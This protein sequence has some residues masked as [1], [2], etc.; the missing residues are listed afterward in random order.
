MNVFD[1]RLTPLLN[2]A[3]GSFAGFAQVTNVNTTQTQLLSVM[4]DTV[5]PQRTLDGVNEAWLASS[6]GFKFT[7]DGQEADQAAAMWVGPNE[8]L[9]LTNRE[10]IMGCTA[11]NDGSVPILVQLFTGSGGNTL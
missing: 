11:G 4:L 5:L 2:A 7:L 9:K 3:D 1:Q 8:L 6:I 10:Q